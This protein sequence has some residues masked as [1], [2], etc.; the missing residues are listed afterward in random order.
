MQCA[1][2]LGGGISQGDGAAIFWRV[3]SSLVLQKATAC[4]KTGSTVCRPRFPATRR[5]ASRSAPSRLGLQPQPRAS[6]ILFCEGRLL[7]DIFDDL[8][9]FVHDHNLLPRLRYTNH[10]SDGACLVVEKVVAADMKDNVEDAI[11]ERQPFRFPLKQLGS[12]FPLSKALPASLEH[13]PRDVETKNLAVGSEVRYVRS[14]PDRY[15]QHAC[16]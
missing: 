8:F 13:A 15:L 14:G 3:Q 7:V 9:G 12:S 10:L 4:G 6:Q 11:V 1:C 16:A 5:P 2:S